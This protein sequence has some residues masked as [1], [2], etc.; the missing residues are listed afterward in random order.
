MCR[1]DGYHK[2][3]CYCPDG[4]IGNAYQICERPE[5]TVDDDCASFLACRNTKCVDPCN[6]VPSAQCSVFNHQPT[7]R[8]PPGYIG[9]PYSA[10]T[11]GNITLRECAFTKNLTFIGHGIIN[12]CDSPTEPLSPS[13]ECTMDADCP[14]R[15]ACFSGTCKDSCAQSQPCGTNAKCTVIDTL[16]MR[17]MVC[18]CLPNFIRDANA[19]CSPGTSPYM[20]SAKFSSIS[21]QTNYFDYL[22]SDY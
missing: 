17:T 15:L 21:F 1:P 5:C 16:P 10:C 19:I 14:S 9:D 12:E 11:L 6:C 3:R 4:Y 22:V 13:L 8:C 18:E 2:A 7:C 20:N